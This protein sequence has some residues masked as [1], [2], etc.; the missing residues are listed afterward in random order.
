MSRS[1]EN[2]LPSRPPEMTAEEM[3]RVRW[4]GWAVVCTLL[5]SWAGWITLLAISSSTKITTHAERIDQHY[6]QLHTTLTEV[7]DDVKQLLRQDRV[8][9]IDDRVKPTPSSILNPQSSPG[10]LP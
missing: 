10:G 9:R 3:Q 6:L 5:L 7:Q 2:L 4:A 1:A 8:A